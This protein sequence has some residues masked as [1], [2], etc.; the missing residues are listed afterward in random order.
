MRVYLFFVVKH[1]TTSGD[2]TQFLYGTMSPMEMWAFT[3]T[4]E[5]VDMIERAELAFGK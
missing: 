5:D 4:E 3:S 1:S 2:F